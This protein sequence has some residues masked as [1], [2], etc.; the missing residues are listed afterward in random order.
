[1]INT[2]ALSSISS[3]AI[4]AF[5][6]TAAIYVVKPALKSFTKL[7]RSDIT[8][9]SLLDKNSN[10]SRN[11]ASSRGITMNRLTEKSEYAKDK[12]IEAINKLPD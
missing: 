4:R 8:V 7:D 2:N 3:I 5:I 12:V 1:M 10:I 6:F 9:K 11:I